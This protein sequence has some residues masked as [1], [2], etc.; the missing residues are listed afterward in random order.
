VQAAYDAGE[1]VTAL[2]AVGMQLMHCDYDLAAKEMNDTFYAVAYAETEDGV[3]FGKP[4]G[5]SAAQYVQA[6]FD[7]YE[8][9]ALRTMLADMLEYGAAAQ[10]LFGYRTDAPA[11]AGSPLNKRPVPR[12]P[13][14]RLPC[15]RRC[16]RTRCVTAA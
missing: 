16:M 10:V 13:H 8:D 4:A 1:G 7:T 11:D 6:A 3:I 9:E 5:M 15:T 14:L 2:T 12:R